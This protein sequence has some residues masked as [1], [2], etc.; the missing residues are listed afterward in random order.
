MHPHCM[1][2]E[3]RRFDRPLDLYR[4]IKVSPRVAKLFIVRF[5]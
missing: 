4:A 3:T 1:K 2:K 5:T